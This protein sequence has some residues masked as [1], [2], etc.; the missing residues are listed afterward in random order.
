M[1]QNLTFL[2]FLLKSWT[3]TS[4]YTL[5]PHTSATTVKFCYYANLFWVQTAKFGSRWKSKL[6]IKATLLVSKV[7]L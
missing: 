3:S 4:C 2:C 6:T 1:L 5:Q 7:V